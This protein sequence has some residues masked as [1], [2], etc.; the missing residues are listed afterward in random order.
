MVSDGAM[1]NGQL[2][3]A[4]ELRGL[5]QAD[6][7]E[8]L[9]DLAWCRDRTRVGVGADM[10]S[11]WERGEKRPQRVYRELLCLL[12]EAQP[13]ELG[14]S[15]APSALGPQPGGEQTTAAGGVPWAEV[16]LALGSPA[17]LLHRYLI[18][19]W[20]NDLMKRR[21]MLKSMGLAAL[22]ST[23]SSVAPPVP[24]ASRFASEARPTPENLTDLTSLAK[25]Y[26][27]LYHDTAPQLLMT[28]IKAHLRTVDD[29]LKR[30]AAPRERR[31]LL[32][33][34]S[35]VSQLAGRLAFFDLRDPLTARGYF[36]TAYD[37]AVAAEDSALAAGALGHLGFVPAAAGQWTA[38]EDHLSHATVHANG[39]APRIVRSWLAAVASE[40]R[41]TAGD[42]RGA[43]IAIDDAKR[44]LDSG[45]PTMVP[46]WFDFYG[47]TRLRGFEGYALLRSG[48]TTKAINQLGDALAALEPSAVKQRTV[49]LTDL[50]SANLRQGDL[51]RACDLAIQAASDLRTRRYATCVGRLQEF[52]S[53][54]RPYGATRAVR[55]LDRAM[56]EL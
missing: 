21:E 49:F 9:A 33:N 17:R 44:A 24:L 32:A 25:S 14:L 19:Q 43:L 13:G 20:E 54:L 45:S 3:R 16:L 38:A 6:V 22:G 36:M 8:R 29:L 2:R 37:S 30:G 10:V 50:A 46:E 41:A 26:Q 27:Q 42:E 55:D 5:T 28:P 12:Y 31:L 48:H 56:V 23:L 15:A 53:T 35:Q 51:D 1:Q 11:K 18:D 52:R 47:G 40:V 7:A 34:H 4:R 39:G